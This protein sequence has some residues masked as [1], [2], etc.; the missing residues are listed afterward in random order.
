MEIQVEPDSSGAKG[1]T[2]WTVGELSYC[3]SLGR[4][5]TTVALCSNRDP[6]EI[7]V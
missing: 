6:V 2:R 7:Y 3:E 1:V 5:L 4:I